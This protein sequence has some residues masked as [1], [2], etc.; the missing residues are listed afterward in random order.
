MV[1][2]TAGSIKRI[3]FV[4]PA[5]AGQDHKKTSTTKILLPEVV[6]VV[7]NN[8]NVC[9]IVPSEIGKGESRDVLGGTLA[10][11]DQE[12]GYVL[13]VQ[14]VRYHQNSNKYEY[15]LGTGA[16]ESVT[17]QMFGW[18]IFPYQS[19][20]GTDMLSVMVVSRVP[21][22]MHAELLDI[23]EK[24]ASKVLARVLLAHVCAI[25]QLLVKVGGD[26]RTRPPKDLHT[27][28]I[29]V[30]SDNGVV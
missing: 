4:P 23:F 20:W 22:T 18:A 10:G 5:D 15:E 2:Q 29:G 3:T 16:L 12:W 17:P 25:I 28:N 19:C 14:H 30:T 1:V 27:E 7:W 9:R 24:P 8:G 13:K 21:K 11:T 6:E 26:L